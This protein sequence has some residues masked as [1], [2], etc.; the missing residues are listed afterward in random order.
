MVASQGRPL[1]IARVMPGRVTA[2]QVISL[3]EVTG[4]LGPKVDVPKLADELGFDMEVLPS[5]L[6]AAEMLGLIMNERGDVSLTELGLR[7]Q[8]TSKKKVMLLKDRLAAIEPFKTAVELAARGKGVTAQTIAD[9]LS[10]IGIKWNYLP[11][12]NEELIRDL[13]IHWTIHGGLLKYDG[14]TGRFEKA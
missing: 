14:R 1:P 3:V 7:F 4:S 6:E 2:G 9:T 5:I 8:K 13:L 10:Q 12:Q 11:E